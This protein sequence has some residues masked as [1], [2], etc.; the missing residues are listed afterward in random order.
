[1]RE[2]EREHRHFVFELPTDFVLTPAE[3]AEV[4]A[5][6]ECRSRAR[7]RWRKAVEWVAAEGLG[8]PHVAHAFREASE[9]TDRTDPLAA[10]EKAWREAEEKKPQ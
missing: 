6:V 4:L 7:A 1:M 9:E 10:Q 5:C 2:K 3:K 8:L